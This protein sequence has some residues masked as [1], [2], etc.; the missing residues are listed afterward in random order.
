MLELC[1]MDSPK[2]KR[3]QNKFA[4]EFDNFYGSQIKGF[5]STGN[6]RRASDI[7]NRIRSVR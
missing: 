5:Y 7:L 4:C 6:I 2:N 1:S 3:G